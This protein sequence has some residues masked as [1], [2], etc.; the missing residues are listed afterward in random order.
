M[1]PT[2]LLAGV[3]ELVGVHPDADLVKNQV[4]NLSVIVAG[5]YRGYLDLGDGSVELW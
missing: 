4:G 1:T 3:T 2:D 5:E